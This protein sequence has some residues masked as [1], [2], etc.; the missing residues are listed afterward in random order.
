ML[1]LAINFGIKWSS[2]RGWGNERPNNR[3]LFTFGSDSGTPLVC[4][5]TR[6]T[7]P[8]F[9]YS[10]LLLLGCCASGATDSMAGNGKAKLWTISKIGQFYGFFCLNISNVIHSRSFLYSPCFWRSLFL[11]LYFTHI[12]TFSWLMIITTSQHQI[13][14]KTNLIL[15]QY[16]D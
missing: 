3:A 13:A 2:E 4:L 15:L 7:P 16:F 11:R 5:G 9:L 10:A 14:L 12:I 8:M 6:W 1:L